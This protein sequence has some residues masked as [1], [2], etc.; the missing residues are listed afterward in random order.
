MSTRDLPGVSSILNNTILTHPIEYR[1]QPDY[2]RGSPPLNITSPAPTSLSGPV[3]SFTPSTSPGISPNLIRESTSGADI[4]PSIGAKTPIVQAKAR[5]TEDK[6]TLSREAP[7]V[8]LVQTP[9]P[10]GDVGRRGE[11]L[12]AKVS[13]AGYNPVHILR[14]S[15]EAGTSGAAASTAVGSSG[16]TTSSMPPNGGNG[17]EVTNIGNLTELVYQRIVEKLREELERRGI[18]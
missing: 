9:S 10:R 16:D 4:S 1:I 17:G 3:S 14:E 7:L 11:F 13:D 8:H 2:L 12:Q 5:V 6:A 15:V 18:S